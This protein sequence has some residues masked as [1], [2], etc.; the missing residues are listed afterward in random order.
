[1]M[2]SAEEIKKKLLELE[3]KLKV[4]KKQK[5]TNINVFDA[6][7][8]ATQEIKHSA[9]FAWLANSQKPHGLG[10]LFLRKFCEKLVAYETVGKGVLQNK[11]IIGDKFSRLETLLD[12]KY[13]VVT[14][15]VVVNSESRI[16]V[17]I[18]SA[19]AQTVIVIENK[20]FTS[21]HDNQL[22]RYEDEI[23]S[24]PEFG[25]YNKIYVY[26]TPQGD[27]PCGE[28][29]E[30]DADWCVFDY[31][32][33]R[34]IVN[35][36]YKNLTGA[37]KDARLKILLEDYTELV[38]NNILKENK[39]IRNLCK[40]IVRE[41]KDAL[42]ILLSYTDNAEVAIG[43]CKDWLENNFDGITVYKGSRLG[44]RFYTKAM[45][46]YLDKSGESLYSENNVFRVGGNLC[47]SDGPVTCGFGLDK[48][49]NEV[50]SDA[51]KKIMRAAAPDKKQGNMYFT[52]SLFELLS[53]QDR[54]Q[55]FE[56]IKPKLKIKL[57]ELEMK[58]KEFDE[59]LALL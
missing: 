10:S 43:Y 12:N 56:E 46:E 41:H 11:E 37:K 52:V 53:E 42:D 40:R 21:T 33:V 25:N 1:M 38:E 58:L 32:G 34:D 36:I 17:F 59:L 48:G 16:D 31:K 23:D 57:T 15:K 6:A 27:L 30:Y 19:V 44:F 39:E 13:D 4:V 51:M 45:K 20:V 55:S 8:M 18:V 54:S 22:Q 24:H 2:L 5:E 7:G 14:E 47:Q 35:E 9:F 3:E 28:S 29:G 26:L 50:W 49:R